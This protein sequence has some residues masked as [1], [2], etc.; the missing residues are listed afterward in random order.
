MK[1]AKTIVLTLLVIIVYLLHQDF[2]NWDK[3]KPLLFGFLPPG[4]AYHAGYS[5]LAAILMAVLVKF[6]WPKHL[7]DV[8]PVAGS[9]DAAK[10]DSH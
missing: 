8:Q 10:P 2:W 7:E 6:A 1:P 4:L 3:A 5:I 9:D